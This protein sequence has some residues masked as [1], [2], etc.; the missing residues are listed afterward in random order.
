MLA[1]QWKE[2]SRDPPG[3]ASLTLT[4]PAGFSYLDSACWIDS[5]WSPLALVHNPKRSANKPLNEGRLR[6]HDINHN[7]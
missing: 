5:V 4:V 7:I 6:P 3:R 1:L 2:R